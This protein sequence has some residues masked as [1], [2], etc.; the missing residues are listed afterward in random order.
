MAWQL[1]AGAARAALPAVGRAL[2][3]KGIKGEVARGAAS[4]MLSKRQQSPD[5]PSASRPSS[6]EANIGQNPGQTWYQIGN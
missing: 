2:T 6:G 4:S 3:S 1:L 5:S